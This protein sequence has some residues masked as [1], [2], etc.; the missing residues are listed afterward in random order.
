MTERPNINNSGEHRRALHINLLTSK[1]TPR[2]VAFEL[3]LGG[4]IKYHERDKGGRG[5]G[6]KVQRWKGHGRSHEPRSSGRQGSVAQRASQGLELSW[7]INRRI[8]KAFPGQ[9]NPRMRKAVCHSEPELRFCGYR[10]LISFPAPTLNCRENLDYSSFFICSL[11]IIIISILKG[12]K[13]S[14]D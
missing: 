11:R 1:E 12:D 7:V 8:T 10:Y 6:A 9:A 13:A 2:R 4:G 14:E 3:D 5:Q